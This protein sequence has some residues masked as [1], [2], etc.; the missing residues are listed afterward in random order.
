MTINESH[1]AR[2][3]FRLGLEW[4]NKDG[5]PSNAAI[6]AFILHYRPERPCGYELSCVMSGRCPRQPVC[7]N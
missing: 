3:A 6:D 5:S 2:V 1:I 7:N 4:Y